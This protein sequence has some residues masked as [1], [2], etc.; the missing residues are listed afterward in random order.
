MVSNESVT[1]LSRALL[2]GAAAV[3]V[4]AGAKYASAILVPL[5]LAVFIGVITTPLFLYLRRYLPGWLSLVVMICGLVVVG[6]GFAQ[7]VEGTINAV[8]QRSEAYSQRISEYHGQLIAQLAEWDSTTR[9]RSW[10]W[11]RH[12][13]CRG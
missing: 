6:V 2:Y 1:A 8:G 7:V 11:H 4:L 9:R 5:L 10:P 3:I 13:L 12:R